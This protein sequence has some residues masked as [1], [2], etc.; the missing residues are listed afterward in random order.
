MNNITQYIPKYESKIEYIIEKIK[1]INNIQI[2]ELGVS[3]GVSTK[4]FLQLCESNNGFLTS[5]DIDN[6]SDV[7]KSDKWKFIHSSDDNFELIDKIIPKEI[8]FLFIDS[9]HEPNHVEKVFYH[10]YKFLKKGG[11]CIIDDTSWL[12]YIK[13]EYR[14]NSSNEYTNRKTFEKILEIS[15]QN[16]EKFLLEFLFDG[17]GLA[18]ITKK[19]NFLN[20]PKKIVSREFSLKSLIRKIFKITPKK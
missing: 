11:V 17:S 3:K 10:Y 15:N 16:K 12:P 7:V 18:I 13:N 4:K 14:D 19:E 9:F 1:H 2:L 20:K 8:D 5:V 6:C